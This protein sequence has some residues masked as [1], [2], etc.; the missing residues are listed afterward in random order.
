MAGTGTNDI[1][2]K[3]FDVS[4]NSGN[5]SGLTHFANRAAE[6]DK[7]DNKI[8]VEDAKGQGNTGNLK[9]LTDFAQ[10]GKVGQSDRQEL[11]KPQA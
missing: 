7:G 3:G 8:E 11:V 10:R 5:T 2:I 9:V 4:N 6:G 1:K